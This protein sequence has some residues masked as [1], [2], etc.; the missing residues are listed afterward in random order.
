VT[1]GLDPDND[2]VSRSDFVRRV[3]LQP[4]DMI[5]KAKVEK[6]GCGR[7]MRWRLFGN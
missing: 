7:A 4:N 3:A 1:R 2:L 6:I 5:H